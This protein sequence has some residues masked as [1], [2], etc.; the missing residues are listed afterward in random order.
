MEWKKFSSPTITTSTIPHH[1]KA[2][3]GWVETIDS[4]SPQSKSKTMAG[5][6]LA[7]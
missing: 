7:I 3:S 5:H 6:S 1:L 2:E 4:T